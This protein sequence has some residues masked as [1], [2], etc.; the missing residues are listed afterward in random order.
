M[1][2]GA[3][4]DKLRLVEV[5]YRGNFSLLINSSQFFI[6]LILFNDKELAMTE[7]PPEIGNNS[8]IAL[9]E[10]SPAMHKKKLL[11]KVEN[12]CKE[13]KRYQWNWSWAHH[14]FTWGAAIFSA[15]SALVIKLDIISAQ[16]IRDNVAAILAVIATTLITIMTTGGFHGSWRANLRARYDL[17]QLANEIDA[18]PAPDVQKYTKRLNDIINEAT[19][20][21]SS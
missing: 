4:H 2:C 16:R 14:T 17:E 18:D 9:N 19:V 15:A 3:S 20:R 6:R 8:K 13:Y 5:N 1:S 12:K 11:D 10:E 7:T 21:K